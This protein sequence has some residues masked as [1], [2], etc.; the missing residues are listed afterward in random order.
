MG[1]KVNHDEA[2]INSVIPEGEYEVIIS[3]VRESE[4]QG[5]TVYI[6]VPMVVRND[7]EQAYKNAIIWHAIWHMKNPSQ[8]DA[9]VGGYNSREIQSIS[10]AVCFENGTEFASLEDWMSALKG[11]L[12][13]V[14]VKHEIYNGNTQAKVKKCEAT[15]LTECAHV[16]K[17]KSNGITPY[18]APSA[19]KFETLGSDDDLPF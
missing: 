15:A 7:V 14:T 9:E 16:L 12:C 17:E 8:S 3:D 10:K 19:P 2:K 5:G 13:R 18:S 11:R 6:N 1:F 4:T